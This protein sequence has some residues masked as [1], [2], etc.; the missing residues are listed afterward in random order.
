M[1]SVSFFYS[2]TVGVLNTNNFDDRLQCESW[3][4]LEK[5][6][7]ELSDPPVAKLSPLPF[8]Y[9]HRQVFLSHKFVKMKN[10][11]RIDIEP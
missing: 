7:K 3:Q 11:G 6:A 1:V 5:Q 10:V 8:I 9:L 2:K 4:M